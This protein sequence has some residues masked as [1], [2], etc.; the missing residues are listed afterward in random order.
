MAAA[1]IWCVSYFR[2]DYER[3]N[4]H[5]K[6]RLKIRTLLCLYFENPRKIFSRS[7]KVSETQHLKKGII[8]GMQLLKPL[9]YFLIMPLTF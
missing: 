2:T 5:F 6:K 3:K 7:K 8:N 4:S 9:N 1:K